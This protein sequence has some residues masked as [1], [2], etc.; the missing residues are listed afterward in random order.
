MTGAEIIAARTRHGWTQK[1]AASM[2][3]ISLHAYERFEWGYP[4]AVQAKKQAIAA[5]QTGQ[6]QPIYRGQG[7]ASMDPDRRAALASQGGKA[8]H[9]DSDPHQFTAEEAV[10][11]GRKGG[12]AVS[13]DREHMRDI[14]RKGGLNRRGKTHA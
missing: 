14:G 3:G 7:F 6:Q 11:A 10:A 5:L 4:V 1:Q 8:A 12:R 13:Q 2:A 9:A